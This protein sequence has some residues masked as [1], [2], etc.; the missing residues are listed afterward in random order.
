MMNETETAPQKVFIQG[1]SC[2]QQEEEPRL[3]T[4]FLQMRKEE[5][6]LLLGS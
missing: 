2:G 5:L 6:F 4:F 3:Y 1:R